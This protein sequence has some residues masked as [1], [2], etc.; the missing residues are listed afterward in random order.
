MVQLNTP[1]SHS[2]LYSLHEVALI[3][4]IPQTCVSDWVADRS[5]PAV[6]LGNGTLRIRAADLAQF[7]AAH[8]QVIETR[9]QP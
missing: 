2:D 4:D 3:L 5:L 8:A 9:R 7:I 6:Q 1:L